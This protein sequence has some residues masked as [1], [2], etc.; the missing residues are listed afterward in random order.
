MFF[1]FLFPLNSFVSLPFL[2]FGLECDLRG[3]DKCL[4]RGPIFRARN[5]T[6]AP[7]RAHKKMD[8]QNQSARPI[9]TQQETFLF[10]VP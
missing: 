7:N 10:L 2:L 6:C 5:F 9:E 1:M 4:S 3:V 8:A